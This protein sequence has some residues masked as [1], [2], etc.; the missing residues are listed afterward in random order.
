MSNAEVAQ[1]L[2]EKPAQIFNVD[3]TWLAVRGISSQPRQEPVGEMCPIKTDV[4]CVIVNGEFI[5]KINGQ[6]VIDKD[7]NIV[8]PYQ[9]VGG[10]VNRSSVFEMSFPSPEKLG[11]KLD[12]MDL[13]PAGSTAPIETAG[14]S[15]QLPTDNETVNPVENN[16]VPPIIP[17]CGGL[18][19]LGLLGGAWIVEAK[20][21]ADLKADIRFRKEAKPEVPVK[22]LSNAEKKKQWNDKF[23][24]NYADKIAHQKAIAVQATRLNNILPVIEGLNRRIGQQ[25]AYGYYDPS[26]PYNNHYLSL[27]EQRDKLNQ[28]IQDIKNTTDK[29]NKEYDARS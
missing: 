17:I 19:V 15:L 21:K 27:I 14:A 25:E 10:I 4:E 5:V 22:T 24:A 1:N 12:T 29:L 28:K 9:I 23:E 26:S 7:G 8:G 18:T 6:D 20:R 13:Y 2:Y 16:Q 3:A 11:A